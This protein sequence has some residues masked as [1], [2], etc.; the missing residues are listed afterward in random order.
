LFSKTAGVDPLRQ[1]ELDRFGNK[2]TW[3][4]IY[5]SIARGQEYAQ[6]DIDLLI[7]GR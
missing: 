3:A 4:A 6:S 7:V 5:G 1:A 2:I